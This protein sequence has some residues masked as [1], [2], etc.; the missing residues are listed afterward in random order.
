MCHEI[1]FQERSDMTVIQDAITNL[2]GTVQGRMILPQHEEFDA[3]RALFYR[4]NDRR[5]SVIIKAADAKD[6]SAVVSFASEKG[7]ELAVRSGGHSLA[8]HSMSNGGV[9]LDLSDMR[10]IEIDAANRTAWAQTGVT[11]GQFTQETGVHGLT[12]GFGDTGTVGIGGITLGGGVG[13]LVRKYGLTIDNLLAA[14]VVTADGNLVRTDAEHLPDLFWAIRGGGGNFGVVTRF[15]YRLCPIDSVV[16]GILMLPA[17]ADII[18]KFIAEAESAPEELSA[19]VNVMRAPAMPFV[20]EEHHGKLIIMALLVYAGTVIDAEPSVAKF[21]SIAKPMIDMVR[22]MK[23]PQM[24]EGPEGPHPVAGAVRN[25]FLDRVGQHTSEAIVD[26][27]NASTASMA[28]MQLRVLGGAMERVPSDATAFA[29]RGRRIMATIAALFEKPDEA[30]AHEEWVTRF[31]GAVQQGREGVYVNFLGNEGSDRIRAAYPGSTWDRLT[32]IK[33][34]YDPS[35]LFRM[36]HN[37]PPV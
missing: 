23:Y 18:R 26:H 36:N 15:Q 28:V 37:I 17:T 5:P 31:M 29:H 20:P 30:P 10:T 9:V 6:I 1:T 33:R 35:N 13:F 32:V 22:P 34:R 12:V 24:F 7:L 19:I 3:A 4:W 11:T 25:F 27:L 21:R 2:R 8:G 16:G 14:D